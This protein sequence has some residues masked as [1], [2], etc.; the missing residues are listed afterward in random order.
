MGRKQSSTEMSD[1]MSRFRKKQMTR[2]V[3]IDNLK[4][5]P[6]RKK[7]M[8]RYNRI[9]DQTYNNILEHQPSNIIQPWLHIINEQA[10]PTDITR[11]IIDTHNPMMG[12]ECDFKYINIELG[13]PSKFINFKVQSY[14]SPTVNKTGDYSTIERNW[15]ANELISKKISINQF[16]KHLRKYRTGVEE[17][18]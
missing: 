9:I 5:S 8:K 15:W 1:I 11:R 2:S 6:E 16:S 10:I 18:Y 14:V 4:N 13:N 12:L 7:L 3:L 17:M